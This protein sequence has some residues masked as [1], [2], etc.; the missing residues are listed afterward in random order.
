MDKRFIGSFLSLYC[1][2]STFLLCCT[3]IYVYYGILISLT[4]DNDIVISTNSSVTNHVIQPCLVNINASNATNQTCPKGYKEIDTSIFCYTDKP[5]PDTICLLYNE[6]CS[7][8]IDCSCVSSSE[9]S[10]LSDQTDSTI[11]TITY[12]V[13]VLI[14]IGLLFVLMTIYSCLV[15]CIEFTNAKK[16]KK[17][18]EISLPY[19]EQ[20]EC[21]K[22][23]CAV[24]KKLIILYSYVI[25]M[26]CATIFILISI[27]LL[28]YFTYSGI[29]DNVCDYTDNKCY[30]LSFEPNAVISLKCNNVDGEQYRTSQSWSG[31]ILVTTI[32]GTIALFISLFM[33]WFMTMD[34]IF[35]YIDGRS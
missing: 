2:A 5:L 10:Y 26:V 15:Y 20:N 14:I 31:I 18:T 9:I 35:C 11:S 3:A 7:K 22:K 6:Y 13:D 30:L 24:D 23:L 16:I 29:D 21:A 8:F 28:P 4:H 32:V 12:I 33:L 27:F 17:E 34:L 1:I 25:L 19:V